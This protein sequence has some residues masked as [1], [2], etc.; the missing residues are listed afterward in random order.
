LRRE[1]KMMVNVTLHKRICA[2]AFGTSSD[3]QHVQRVLTMPFPA[4]G[5]YVTWHHEGRE[6][7][8]QI[9]EV[10]WD[11]DAKVANAYLSYDIEIQQTMRQGK[12]PRPV[13]E[14]VREYLDDGWVREGPSC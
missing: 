7:D 12:K 5:T 13:E 11:D 9:E 4:P 2:A 10:F 1:R 3:D 8:V 6:I 14:I